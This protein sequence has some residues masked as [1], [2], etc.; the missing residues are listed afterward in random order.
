MHRRRHRPSRARHQ[1]RRRCSPQQTASPSSGLRSNLSL[2]SRHLRTHAHQ[3][4]PEQP[5]H[6]SRRALSRGTKPYTSPTGRPEQP[7]T[8]ERHCLHPTSTAPLA[9]VAAMSDSAQQRLHFDHL[10]T[11]CLQ[12]NPPFTPS[13]VA[14]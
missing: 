7:A 4:I 2:P 10:C 6:A 11:T 9:E 8:R 12:Q 1:C 5:P 13:S 14:R 3:R